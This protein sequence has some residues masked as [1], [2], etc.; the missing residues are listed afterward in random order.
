M[1][2]IQFFTTR[3][4]LTNLIT[5][6]VFI[7]GIF[8]WYNTP[9]EELPDADFNFARVR[10]AYPG[11]TAEDVEHFI[12]RPIEEKLKGVDGLYRVTSTSSAGSCS[13]RIEINQNVSVLSEVINE[14]RSAVLDAD[15]PDDLIDDPNIRQF[16]TTNALLLTNK[17]QRLLSV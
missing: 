5:V 11:S 13:I 6:L 1:K 10:V 7:A 14:I 16:K 15:L 8:F 12:T 9:R 4:L 17:Q 2:F 3:H